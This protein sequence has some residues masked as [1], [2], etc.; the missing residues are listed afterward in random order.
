[1][2]TILVGVYWL[3]I[4]GFLFLQV[5]LSKKE[6]HRLGLILPCITFLFSLITLLGIV[7]FDNRSFWNV[8]ALFYTLFF[9]LIFQPLYY[10][11]FILLVEKTKTKKRSRKNEYSGF[12]VIL[13]IL[14]KR[15]FLKKVLFNFVTHLKILLPL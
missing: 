15:T 3:G 5:F 4:I 9:I 13:N 7:V 11:L 1:M 6:N 12:K 8:L 2:L 10:L 14:L